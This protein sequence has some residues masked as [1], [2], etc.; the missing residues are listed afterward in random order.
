MRTSRDYAE[1]ATAA[2]LGLL[3]ISPSDS[4]AERVAGVIEEVVRGAILDRKELERQ[5]A[6]E[7]REATAKRLLSLLA[8][9]PAVIYS[10]KASGDYAPTFVSDN[11][12]R[13]LGYEPSEY[14]ENP[15]FWRERV[16]PDDLA[17]VE[18][19]IARM[20][21]NG[22]HTLE[23][24]FRRK[25]GSYCWVN[26]DQHLVNDADG[27]PLEIVGSWS[28]ISARKRAEAENSAAHARLGQLLL[29]SPAVIYSFEARGEFRP[30]FIS[31]NVKPVL[32]YDPKEYLE[33]P[34][35]WRRCVHPD[36]LA[37][38]EAEFP[39]LFANG[40]HT[41]EY[42]FRKKDGSHCWVSDDWHLVRDEDGEPLEIVGSWN[43]ITAR[44]NAEAEAAAERERVNRLLAHAP[45][46]IYSFRATGDFGPTFISENV[47][48]LLGYKQKEYLKDPNFWM[49]RLHPDD[50]DRVTAGFGKLFE[51]GDHSYEYRFRRADGSYTWVGDRL[52]LIR[53]AD[54]NPLEVVGSW[55]DISARKLAE[56][57][58]RESEQRLVD[59]IESI[60]EGFAFYNVEDRLVTC[61][62]R[63]R[64]MF[65]N[66]GTDQIVPGTPFAAIIRKVAEQ[67][68]VSEVNGLGID[69]W[70]EERM[71]RHRNPGPPLMQRRSDGRWIQISERRV[72]GGGIVA[73]YSD[74]T[75]LKEN[76][77]RVANAHRLILESLHYAS[78]IQTAMLPARRTLE[79]VMHDHFLVWEPRDI[80]GGDFFWFHRTNRGYF[81]IL[82]DCTGHG[83][84]GAFMTLI[85]CGLLDRH[86]RTMEEPS[87]AALLNKLHRDLQTMLGQDTGRHGEGMTDD[88]FDAGICFINPAERSLLYAG[89]RFPLLLAR[90]G[91]IDEIKGDRAGVGYRRVPPDVAFSEIRLD[92][93][94]GDTFYMTTDGLI[95]QVG[96]ERRRSFGRRRA[97]D[98]LSQHQGSSMAEQRDALAAAFAHHQGEEK[99]RD[100]VTVIGFVP[101]AP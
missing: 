45:A 15:G 96:G 30:T 27:K 41:V 13:L 82:G 18:A 89:A 34:D 100:D 58:Q 36:D 71:E 97:V 19:E 65:H 1:G 29:A 46:V 94:G 53:D 95:D 5:R 48:R 12:E 42:R 49:D 14:L 37:A 55:S 83:V 33:S 16:H 62:S 64:E 99:R 72:S 68:Q 75:A 73:V 84:P 9:S 26:D 59:A 66:G 78:R 25:D 20:V 21:G 40:H 32:G 2:V 88:G 24:R 52:Y 57:A 63:Y 80:V 87:P 76:E 7:R 11:L 101:L 70:I 43:D 74:L 10:F 85:A 39:K 31:E 81:I 35:F 47:K 56:Q 91:A 28:D 67:G 44:R 38:V 61:N 60:G 23:Y 54:G 86:L 51:A 4:D 17:R 79:T 22:G 8:W 50:K 92:L 93:E 90:N 77:E 3:S 69:A 98:I 6:T